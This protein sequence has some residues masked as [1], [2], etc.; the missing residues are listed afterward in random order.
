MRLYQLPVTKIT[1]NYKNL[2]T[3]M[4]FKNKQQANIGVSKLQLDDPMRISTYFY[5][6]HELRMIS[7]VLN[8]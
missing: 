3:S 7:I 1:L 5:V 2:P 4:A 6:S 8:G